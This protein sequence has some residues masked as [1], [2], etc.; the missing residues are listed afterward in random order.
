MLTLLLLSLDIVGGLRPLLHPSIDTG[1]L[2]ET[3]PSFRLPEEPDNKNLKI[4]RV[5]DVLASDY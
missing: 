5:V 2:L 1:P 4:G 3:G